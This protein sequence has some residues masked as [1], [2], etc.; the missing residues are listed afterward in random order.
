MANDLQEI[1]LLALKYF[2]KK[3]KDKG[4]TQNKLASKLGVTQSYVSAVLNNTKKASVELQE[5]LANILYGPYEE[6]LAVGRRLQ[7]GLKPE[8]IIKSDRDEKV[9]SL[10]NTLVHY[11]RD[12][13]RIEKQLIDTKNFYKIIIE[14][15]TS[16]ILVTDQY[17]KIY[18]VNTWLLNQKDEF[19][20]SL[21]GTYVAD[22]NAASRPAL[23]DG[24]LRYY[25]RAKETLEP[26]EFTKIGLISP[27]G[28]KI[29]RSGWCTPVL[30]H[31]EYM[32]MIVT[33]S[34]VTEEILLKKKLQEEIWL[35]KCAME[36][37]DQVGWM[38]LDGSKRII[39]RNAVYK[40]MFDIPEK[41]LLENSYSQNIEWVKHLMCDQENFM[42]LNVELSKQKKKIM[43]EFEL[44]DGRRIRRVSS[45]FFDE[46][47]QLL[48]WNIILSDITADKAP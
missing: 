45:P 3:Y 41:V 42:R 37:M 35:M 13:Q 6:F 36:S 19:N 32:G 1:F 5:R 47:D 46:N 21:L 17:D 48:G 23:L 4:G 40:K 30:D 10:I 27:S 24:L 26:Q 43:H 22:G 11:I 8:L 9:E 31:Q 2:Y 15:I 12:Y 34:D 18:F 44:I 33:V 14:K 7:Y 29:Y 20:E 38:I 25:L 39:K 28:R 16:G